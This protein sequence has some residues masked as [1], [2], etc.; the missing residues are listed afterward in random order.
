MV[1]LDPASCL[2]DD[3]RNFL[4]DVGDHDGRPDDPSRPLIATEE[5][6]EELEWI[7][8]KDAFPAVETFIL[9]EQVG[10]IAI[11]K[12]QSPVSV[13]ENSTNSSSA[14]LMSSCGGLKP[15]HRARTK[16]RRRRSEIPAQQLFWNQPIESKPSRSHSAS[17]SA[18]KLDIGRKCLHCGT[19]QTPQWR[20][21]PFG[22]KTLC[23]ACGVRYKSGRL[24][25]EYRPASSPT[26]SSEM[27]SNSH[28]KVLEMRKQKYGMGM[29]VKPEDT[30]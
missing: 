6:E 30:G 21:G 12:H 15:P 7:S 8:N 20:A 9:S 11:A 23:N 14:S 5:A 29:V 26:F 4:S 28:R 18:S 27:H 1:P 2:V 3:L 16:G 13:L 22:P 19:D 25:P 10:G 24:C 17:A